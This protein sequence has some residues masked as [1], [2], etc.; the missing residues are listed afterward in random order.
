MGVGFLE[1]IE[2]AHGRVLPELLQRAVPLQV[3]ADARLVVTDGLHQK[4]G[5]GLVGIG[6]WRHVR[7]QR[8]EEALFEQTAQG[9]QLRIPLVSSL[10]PSKPW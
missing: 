2:G 3:V 5:K 7:A 8:V 4:R 1:V 10:T 6:P 9:E